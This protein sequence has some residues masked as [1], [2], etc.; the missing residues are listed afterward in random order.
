MCATMLDDPTKSATTSF[1]VHKGVGNKITIEAQVGGGLIQ[2]IPTL[3][4]FLPKSRGWPYTTRW[5]YTPY[6]TGKAPYFPQVY[7]PPMH[8]CEFK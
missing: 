5:A 3:V 2:G 7:V 1:E 6:F 4:Q 8:K